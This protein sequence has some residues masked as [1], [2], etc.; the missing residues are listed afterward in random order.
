MCCFVGKSRLYL[1]TIVMQDIG[2]SELQI[3][4]C[5]K[6]LHSLMHS[7]GIRSPAANNGV[8][9]LRPTAYRLPTTGMDHAMAGCEQLLGAIGP[10]STS[11]FGIKLFMK[12]LIDAEPWLVEPS[13]IP[14]P[15]REKS[16]GFGKQKQ[17]IRVA[18]MLDDGVVRP[19]PPIRRALDEV[20]SKM[21]K[22]KEIEVVNWTPSRCDEAWEILVSIS[23]PY[24]GMTTDIQTS[25]ISTSP[26]VG[27]QKPR[28]LTHLANHGGL[29][30]A[31]SSPRILMS[32]TSIS[33]ACGNG[34]PNVKDFEPSMRQSGI[35]LQRR[36][37]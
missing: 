37:R 35:Q 6:C 19:H 31:G 20:V 1:L 29:S 18:V 26:M 25:R 36:R 15:W 17:K 22:R 16:T 23:L 2:G 3:E 12:T 4:V 11:I 34:P 9:G 32:P 14:L 21:S 24:D 10:L 7:S 5:K 33:R 13:L 30:L 28:L 27:A 8:F